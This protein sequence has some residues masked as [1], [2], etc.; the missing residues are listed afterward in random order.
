M[1]FHTSA[2]IVVSW[3]KLG[4]SEGLQ[5]QHFLMTAYSSCGQSGGLSRRS[6]SRSTR[7]KIWIEESDGQEC[8]KL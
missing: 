4:L 7:H 2:T 8:E 1:M 3:A 5:A 6:P